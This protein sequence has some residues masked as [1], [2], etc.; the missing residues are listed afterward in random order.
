MNSL[1]GSISAELI[2]GFFISFLTVFI[3]T[4]IVIKLGIH[5]KLFDSFSSRKIHT[6]PIPRI[7]GIAIYFSILISSIALL[8]LN[9]LTLSLLSGMT[10]IF[11]TGLLDDIIGLSAFQ[12][13]FGQILTASSVIYFGIT[14]DFLS[15]PLG[16]MLSLSWIAIPITVF[17]FV[18]IIN[19][20]NLMDG[21]DGLSAGIAAISA[22]TLTVVAVSTEQYYAAIISVIILGSCLGF[23]RFNFY[24]ARIFMGDT[25]AMLL[26]FLLA[27][28]ATTGVMKSTITFPLFL[29]IVIMALPTL[30]TFLAITRRLKRKQAIFS[31]DKDHIHHYLIKLGLSQKQ[32]VLLLYTSAAIFG[33]L[34][35]LLSQI[36]GVQYYL[37]LGFTFLILVVGV[38]LFKKKPHS[39]LRSLRFFI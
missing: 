23:L 28:S 35:I 21:L 17:W 15:S 38:V 6:S 22:M 31:A 20:F 29:P 32:A 16:G 34:A 12:K 26:G 10:I 9:N 39:I 13:L 3:L 37:L 14:I 4:P 25:G 7:G 27:F 8:P 36:S 30:D 24:P 33:G 5:Y 18:S 1:F 19:M 11:I 2:N